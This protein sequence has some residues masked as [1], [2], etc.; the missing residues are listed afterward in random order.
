MKNQLSSIPISSF[1]HDFD[2]ISVPVSSKGET[3]VAVH[4]SALFNEGENMSIEDASRRARE[5]GGTRHTGR[6]NQRRFERNPNAWDKIYF[7]FKR[8]SR[9]ALRL[10][11]MKLRN[12]YKTK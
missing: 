12:Q 4:F 9:F 8:N 3:R 2:F 10:D 1:R 6:F 5:L 11:I 7:V